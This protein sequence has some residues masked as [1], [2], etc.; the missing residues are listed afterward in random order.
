MS[1]NRGKRLNKS[2]NKAL[3]VLS[4][5][6]L[7]NGQLSA[8]EVAK[9]LRIPLGSLYPILHSLE[10]HGYLSR[11]GSKR[12]SLGYKFLEHANIILRQNNLYTQAKPFLRKLASTY[13]VNAHLGVLY[14][15]KVLYLYREVGGNNV[16]IGEI[17]GWKEPAYC[18]AIGKVLLAYLP[19]HELE[20]YL[21]REQF[22]AF[23]PNTIVEPRELRRELKRIRQD[24]FAISDEEAHEGVVGVAAPIMDIHDQ[25][26]AAISISVLK[27][28]FRKERDE[29]VAAVKKT[30]FL[31]SKGTG[32]VDQ[33]GG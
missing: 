30:A 33:K 9:I 12:Y 31:I 21:A 4:V 6:Q 1:K 27:T 28:R 8:T 19:S 22:I 10:L 14:E 32:A 24:G 11:D 26:R 3:A 25:V 23:T 15:Q 20:E 17:I 13:S 7:Q 2:V 16:V 5:F 18:T 29:L